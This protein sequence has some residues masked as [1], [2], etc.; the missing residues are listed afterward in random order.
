[1]IHPP[2]N[3][4]GSD[5]APLEVFEPLC[6]VFRRT[7]KAEGLKYTPERAHVLD[8]IIRFDGPFQAERVVDAVKGGRG[9]PGGPGGQRLRIS[10]ATVYRTIKLLLDAGIIQRLPLGEEQ[11]FYHLVYGRRPSD[12]IIRTDTR[13]MIPIS[14]P[15]LSAVLERVCRAKGLTPQGH[16]LYVYAADK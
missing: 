15:E 14:V 6:A 4:P 10:K 8:T 2:G 11:G 5:A 13:E 3:T 9:Q 16:R 1:M 7:L 12:M